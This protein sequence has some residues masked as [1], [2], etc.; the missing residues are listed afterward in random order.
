MK[1]VQNDPFAK[2]NARI[3]KIDKTTSS[4]KIG[5]QFQITSAT[6]WHS[7]N[8]K[9]IHTFVYVC[10][11][12]ATDKTGIEYKTVKM[13]S[14]TGRPTFKNVSSCPHAGSALHVF[15]LDSLED[16]SITLEVK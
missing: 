4:L 14:E 9:G 8:I 11:V 1:T 15:I 12:T 3:A 7:G 16:G 2:F 13:V 10:E 6:K 5:T